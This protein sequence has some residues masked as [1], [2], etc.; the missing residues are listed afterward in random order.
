MRL[1]L[2]LLKYSF[3]W[4]NGRVK[5]L[6][7][8]SFRFKPLWYLVLCKIVFLSVLLICMHFV[9]LICVAQTLY[10]IVVLTSGI[11]C[12]SWKQNNYDWIFNA[13]IEAKSI[14]YFHNCDLKFSLVLWII[15][16]WWT[17]IEYT[18]RSPV[19]WKGH[20]RCIPLLRRGPRIWRNDNQLSVSSSKFSIKWINIMFLSESH[21]RFQ[22]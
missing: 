18:M 7:I 15:F 3:L 16:A 5:M 9:A 11:N 4:K 22:S 20:T 17:L 19:N 8:T 10:R 12:Y 2:R 14:I 1:T 21:F 13:E 6:I